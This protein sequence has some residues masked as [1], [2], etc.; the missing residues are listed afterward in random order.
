MLSWEIVIENSTKIR[1]YPHSTFEK[2]IFKSL[3]SDEKITY[4]VQKPSQNLIPRMYSDYYP[5]GEASASSVYSG[6][7]SAWKAFDGEDESS[8]WSRW[9]SFPSGVFNGEWIAYEFDSPVSI[10]AYNITPETGGSINRTPNSWKVQGWNGYSWITLDSRSG[11][12]ISDWAESYSKDFSVTSTGI[13]K[14]YRLFVEST[15]GSDATSIRKF[16]IYGSGNVSSKK[17]GS[18]VTEVL[19]KSEPE[20]D[21]KLLIYPNPSNGNFTLFINDFSSSESVSNFSDTIAYE[22]MTKNLLFHSG[23]YVAQGIP[24][25]IIDITGKIVY[26][27]ILYE[28]ETPLSLN[29]KTGIY[30]VKA[31]INSEDI[32]NKVYIK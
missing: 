11:I 16:K 4:Y 14:K 27:T 30:L 31:L 10:E 1:S 26:T 32:V 22:N 9:I 19:E 20:K 13:Y 29:L 17:S 18:M 28:N 24:I 21:S 8:A 5:S 2:R 6:S 15:N 25:E 23:N 7:Y 3:N 12:T